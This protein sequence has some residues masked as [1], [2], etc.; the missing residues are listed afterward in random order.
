M[1]RAYHA[2]N[3]FPKLLRKHIAVIQIVIS[4]MFMKALEYLKTRFLEIFCVGDS[5]AAN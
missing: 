2:K 3:M 5:I 4:R 1:V